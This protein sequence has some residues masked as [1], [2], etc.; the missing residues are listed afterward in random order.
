MNKALDALLVGLS[1]VAAKASGELG[2][3]ATEQD[4]VAHAIKLR[5]GMY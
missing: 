3:N 5:L 4:I 2:K 1:S